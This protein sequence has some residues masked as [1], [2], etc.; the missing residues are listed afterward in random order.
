[1]ET[2]MP[3]SLPYIVAS[4][5]DFCSLASAKPWRHTVPKR[6]TKSTYPQLEHSCSSKV[7]EYADRVSRCQINDS[8]K[9]KKRRIGPNRGL[10][11][12]PLTSE[13]KD[14]KQEFYH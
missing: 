11:P 14:P 12:R 10:N 3:L 9:A 2:K 6:P 8:K 4:Q 5:S 1:M 13:M 7:V